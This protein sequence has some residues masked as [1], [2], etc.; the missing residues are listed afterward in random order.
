MGATFALTEAVVANQREKDDALNGVAG[1]CA[2]G[3]LAGLR[4]SFSNYCV[5]ESEQTLNSQQPVL[6]RW[7]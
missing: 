2:A 1:G 5:F 7:Q 4:G 6:C 3:F